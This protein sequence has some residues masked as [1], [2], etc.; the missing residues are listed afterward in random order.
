M[1]G[2]EEIEILL[3]SLRE[4]E[5]VQRLWR[6]YWDFLRLPADFQG[7]EEE[8][9]SLPGV[10]APP[11]GRLLLARVQGNP[12]GT[13]ALRPL[14]GR[15]CEAKRMYVPPSYRGRGIGRA[16]LVRLIQE[17]RA[18]EYEEMY[19]DTLESLE[20]ALRLYAQMGFS[21]VPPYSSYPTPGAIYLKRSL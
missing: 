14:G 10:Y 8:R 7:F 11:K 9:G 21:E 13:A 1:N 12:A 17:A 19:A 16:L 5:A 15:A 4:I 18:E 2:N 20:A 6:E 3:V